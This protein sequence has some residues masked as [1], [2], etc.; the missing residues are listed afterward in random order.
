MTDTPMDQ[1]FR[2]RIYENITDTFGFLKKSI[3]KSTVPSLLHQIRISTIHVSSVM[4]VTK[5]FEIQSVYK[6]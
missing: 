3:I 4:L 6:R 5:I 1:D 2:G